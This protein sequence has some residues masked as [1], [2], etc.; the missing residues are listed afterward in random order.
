MNIT[1]SCWYYGQ[2]FG[3]SCRRA[4]I[5][6]LLESENVPMM[7]QTVRSK[8]HQLTQSPHSSSSL[9][10]FRMFNSSPYTRS[11]TPHIVF[12]REQNSSNKRQAI[13]LKNSN[14]MPFPTSFT[15]VEQIQLNILFFT[16][17]HSPGRRDKQPQ[18][19]V[20]AFQSKIALL[21]TLLCYHFFKAHSGRKKELKME[22][23]QS[24]RAKLN[25]T[26]CASFIWQIIS[27]SLQ[28]T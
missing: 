20:E 10:Q 27:R 7:M 18:Q 15:A 21:L 3:L 4:R 12:Q 23:S 13:E 5:N 17:L 19:L 28:K 6:Y 16:T 1:I 22:G 9:N 24:E 8:V 25:T 2:T 14:F 11:L 26:R